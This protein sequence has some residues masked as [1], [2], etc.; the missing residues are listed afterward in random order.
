MKKSIILWLAILPFAGLVLTACD[1]FPFFSYDLTITL[2]KT[3]AR[4]GDTVSATVVYKNTCYADLREVELPKWI[5]AEGGRSKK[6]ILR[7]VFTSDEEFEWADYI[8]PSPVIDT[9][10][11]RFKIKKDEVI[12][13]TFTHT[14]TSEEDL[15]V[16]AAAFFKYGVDESYYPMLVLSGTDLILNPVKIKVQQGEH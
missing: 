1:H 12:R 2:D 11:I 7:A 13:K 10:T 3:E 14:I 15:Y 6:D 5:A 9:K 8:P 4:V 16:H